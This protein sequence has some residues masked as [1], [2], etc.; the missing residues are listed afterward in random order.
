VR[1]LAAGSEEGGGVSKPSVAIMP[2]FIATHMIWASSIVFLPVK[3]RREKRV[4][5][6][7]R[8]I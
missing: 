7:R 2:L 8:W 5:V 6:V 4:V 3:R 1:H